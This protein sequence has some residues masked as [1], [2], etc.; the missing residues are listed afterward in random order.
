MFR[1]GNLMAAIAT[2]GGTPY[3]PTNICHTSSIS[4]MGRAMWQW[5]EG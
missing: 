3:G 1:K 4:S 2:E 5:H